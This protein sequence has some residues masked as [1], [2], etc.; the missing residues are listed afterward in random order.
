MAENMHYPRL[1]KVSES[2][3]RV[4]GAHDYQ[5]IQQMGLQG[6]REQ[7]K[8]RSFLGAITMENLT[9]IKGNQMGFRLFLSFTFKFQEEKRLKMI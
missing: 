7:R 8:I 5:W 9:V 4:I 1:S 3:R 2:K 6:R